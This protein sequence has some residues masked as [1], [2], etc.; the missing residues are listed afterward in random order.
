[1]RVMTET[2]PDAALIGIGAKNVA[3]KKASDSGDGVFESLLKSVEFN[4]EDAGKD[5]TIVNELKDEE[6]NTLNYLYQLLLVL[7]K[8][9]VAND[10]DVNQDFT[11]KQEDAAILTGQNPLENIFYQM[12]TVDLSSEY[13]QDIVN[14]YLIKHKISPEIVEQF[15]ANMD[16]QL[17]QPEV[18]DK[19]FPEENIKHL[20][21]K[22]NEM[23]LTKENIIDKT[24]NEIAGKDLD[25]AFSVSTVEIKDK[26]INQG[27]LKENSDENNIKAISLEKKNLGEKDLISSRLE[28]NEIRES[29]FI[30]KRDINLKSQGQGYFE[31]Q[32]F[33][34]YI[35]SNGDAII[36]KTVNIPQSDTEA[37][38]EVIEQ[39]IH[40][41]HL[42]VK[43]PDKELSVS[44]KPDYLGKV[45]IKVMSDENGMKAKLFIQNNRVREMMQSSLQNLKDQ[46]KQQNMHL[47]DINIYE[48]SDNWQTGSFE[49]NFS[50][51]DNYSSYKRAKFRQSEEVDEIE[52][53]YTRNAFDR[54]SS[55]NY[56]I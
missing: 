23:Q 53:T 31:G 17:P 30:V 2:I 48:M 6:V 54:E 52:H 28:Q 7:N 56:V 18:I 37:N 36:P 46:V 35:K 4:E 34:N 13:I 19:I 44:L 40:K 21:E 24:D 12:E 41:V 15:C 22:L 55:I 39:I 42:A 16:T 43:G 32:T 26:N 49:Q 5:N 9:N 1:M 20:L 29:D 27:Q 51:R 38:L 14:D 50:R 45:L 11:V 47:T 10:I 3:N 33:T 8:E 25:K